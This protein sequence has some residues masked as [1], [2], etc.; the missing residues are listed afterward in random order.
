MLFKPTFAMKNVLE[1]TPEM[2]NEMGIKA[3]ILD[4][5]NTLTTH[6]NPRPADELQ[7]G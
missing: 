5:D 1:I 4:L 7:S 6:N 2:L 3:L